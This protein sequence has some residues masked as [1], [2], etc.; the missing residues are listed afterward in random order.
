MLAHSLLRCYYVLNEQR[1][2]YNIR[3]TIDNRWGKSLLLLLFPFEQEGTFFKIFNFISFE[4]RIGWKKLA[5][6][7]D[8]P[9]EELL[10]LRLI[11]TLWN[12]FTSF[13]TKLYFFGIVVSRYLSYVYLGVRKSIFLFTLHPFEHIYI[14]ILSSLHEDA[15]TSLE[16]KKDNLLLVTSAS[17]KLRKRWIERWQCWRERAEKGKCQRTLLARL[18]KIGAIYD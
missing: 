6:D 12:S 15:D 1:W 18:L 13:T 7:Q 4:I 3:P 8:V 5:L 14:Y 9:R 11:T 16:T 10:I 17:D 2:K